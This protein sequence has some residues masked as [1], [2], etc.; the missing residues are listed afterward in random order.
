MSFG[1]GGSRLRLEE[2]ILP[3]PEPGFQCGDLVGG[4][5]RGSVGGQLCVYAALEPPW[6]DK[7][8][9][10]VVVPGLLSQPTPENTGNVIRPV[11]GPGPPASR[12]RFPGREAWRR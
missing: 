10:D 5:L 4:P 2:F 1:G 8:V 12:R 7:K 3:A 11:K 6:M 9:P